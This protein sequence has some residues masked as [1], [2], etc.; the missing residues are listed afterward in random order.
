MH[1]IEINKNTGQA[2]A[3]FAREAAWHRLGT[4]TEDAMTAEEA[5]KTAHLDGWEVETM[6]LV[7]AA[8]DGSPLLV[9]N[10]FATVRKSP[11]TDGQSDPLGIV[12]GDYEPI[13]N[14]D[15][16]AWL[17][18]LADQS[19]AKF[20]S[21]GSLFDGARVFVAM[22]MEEQIKIGG[23]DAFGQY[24]SAVT[25]HDGSL[26]LTTLVTPIRI[27]CQNT[28]SLALKSAQVT[29]K[30]RHT[31]SIEGRVQEARD[32]L[33][34]TLG[35]ADAFTAAME[36][37]LDREMTN[38]AFD[39]LIA[40]EFLPLAENAPHGTLTR[41]EA[42]RNDLTALFRK[43]DTQ[44]FGRGTR[45]AA[46]NAITEWSEWV[47]PRDSATSASATLFGAGRDLRQR[48]YALLSK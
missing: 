43:A 7:T 3:A 32:V 5:L 14:E 46:F 16:F 41:V 44:D 20:V 23:E 19:G 39:A 37:L 34:I 1:A 11:W 22:E 33:G 27:V 40:K 30:V 9:P 21:A 13:Q 12:G 10:R 36:D 42:Q 18:N 26:A 45:Y 8:H 17:N 24:L 48:A 6:P 15:A 29:H 47:R 2:A 28:A 4:V 38:D 25:S 35:Y 31:G